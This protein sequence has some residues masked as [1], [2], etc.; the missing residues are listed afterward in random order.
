MKFY[1]DAG[2]AGIFA[3][4]GEMPSAI[5]EK[6]GMK[7]SEMILRRTAK[8][9]DVNGQSFRPYHPDY[10]EYRKD[11]G[12]RVDIVDLNFTGKMYASLTHDVI[13]ENEVMLYFA[14]DPQAEKAQ[15]NNPKRQ[16]F[17]LSQEEMD[18]LAELIGADWVEYVLEQA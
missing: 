14:G 16:F 7:A 18:E 11:K 6:V 12:R 9:V 17:A 2:P 13:S 8:G 10:A 1:A 15:H 3:R 5:M 4:T